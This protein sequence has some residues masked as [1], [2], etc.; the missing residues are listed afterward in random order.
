MDDSRGCNAGFRVIRRL[1]HIYQ[2]K[3]LEKVKIGG[4][5]NGYDIS[6]F[7]VWEKRFVPAAQ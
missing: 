1:P 7:P 6:V 5:V 4:F 3:R 2:Y